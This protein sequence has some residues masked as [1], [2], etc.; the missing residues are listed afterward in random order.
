M[1]SE[2]TLKQRKF[3]EAFKGNATEAARVARSPH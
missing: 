1:P 2:L 3:V